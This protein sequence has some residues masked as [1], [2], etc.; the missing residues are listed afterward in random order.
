[1]M[2][3]PRD[4]PH[5]RRGHVLSAALALS[6]TLTVA[7]T[8]ASAE[9]ATPAVYPITPDPAACIVAPVDVDALL[10]HLATPVAGTVGTPAPGAVPVGQPADAATSAAVAETLYDVFACANAGDLRRV[11]ALF[12]ADFQRVFFAGVPPADLAAIL[13]LP[14]APLPGAE[15]RIIRAIGEVQ[16]LADG[17]A[18]VTIVLDEPDDPRREEP[19]YA[20]LVWNGERW[21]VDAIHEDTGI[22]PPATPGATP[23]A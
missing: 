4:A 2:K 7:I 10:G 11:V 22:V 18:G 23:A 21:L 17:R 16:L 14:P 13:A 19:D 12:S 8:A 6:L 3:P 20:L 5:V 15:R 9:R 1:M